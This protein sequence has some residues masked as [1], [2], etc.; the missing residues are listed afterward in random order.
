[1]GIGHTETL[2]VGVP[3]WARDRLPAQ[4]IG[5]AP[6]RPVPAVARRQLPLP[7]AYLSGASCGIGR[8]NEYAWNDRYGENPAG[9][10][11]LAGPRIR[12]PGAD[13]RLICLFRSECAWAIRQHTVAMTASRHASRVKRGAGT[14]G[15]ACEQRMRPGA[16]PA[17][18]RHNM[19]RSETAEEPG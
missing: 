19:R 2:R 1:M 5:Q 3:S 15:V 9:P 11:Q 4:R 16:G 7:Q 10:A 13:T 8:A 12:P 17:R 6:S 18:L 14:E